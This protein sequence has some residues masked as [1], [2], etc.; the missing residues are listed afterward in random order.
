LSI[1]FLSLV[2]IISGGGL[3]GVELAAELA[4]RMKNSTT[5]G[6]NYVLIT[7]STAI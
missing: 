3:V 6:T 5:T 7:V 4:Y 2:I 1:C